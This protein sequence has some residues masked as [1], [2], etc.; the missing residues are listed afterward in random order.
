[1]NSRIKSMEAKNPALYR[2]SL[3]LTGATFLLILAGGLVT[4]HEAGLAVPD[5]PLSYGRF[6]PPMVGNIFWEHGHRM[7]AGSVGILTL[8]FAFCTQFGTAAYE[9]R[10]A[11][12]KLAWIAL[13]MVVAQALL[14]GLTVI[15]MLPAPVSIAH[16]CLAQTFFCV[17]IALA[18]LLSG[19]RLAP[20]ADADLL[21]SWKRLARTLLVTAILVYLQLI[22]GATLRHTGKVLV[23]HVVMAFIV[24]VHVLLVMG[25]ILRFHGEKAPL[26]RA[27]V[28]LGLLTLVQIFLGMGSFI[29][30]RMLERGYAPT[31]GEVFFTAAHQ[32]TGALVLGAVVLMNVMVRR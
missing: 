18:Y 12:R 1:M 8:L 5:W 24:V 17:L 2:F 10:P 30:T 25:R 15:Y 20:P 11:L 9:I 14:G 22:L 27:G 16:A 21:R 4:S 13:G 32:S 31:H 3:V 6:F 28:G 7:I 29:F 23:P 26:S 19:V